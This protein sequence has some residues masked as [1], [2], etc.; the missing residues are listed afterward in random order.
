LYNNE[1][2]LRKYVK[3]ISANSNII[4]IEELFRIFIVYKNNRIKSQFSIIRDFNFI[5]NKFE[6]FKTRSK[7][8]LEKKLVKTINNQTS[9][10]TSGIIINNLVHSSIYNFYNFDAISRNSRNLHLASIEYSHKLRNFF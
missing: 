4:S 5:M 6:F 3:A 1:G 8:I 2:L 9:E 7:P 10:P